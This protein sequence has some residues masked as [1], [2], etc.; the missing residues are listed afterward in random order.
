MTNQDAAYECPACH[1]RYE[2]PGAKS[3]CWEPVRLAEDAVQRVD[4]EALREMRKTDNRLLE[5]GADY[6]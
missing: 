6:A 5:E 2:T 4:H 3:C 1:R